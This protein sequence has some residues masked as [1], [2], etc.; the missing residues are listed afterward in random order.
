MQAESN[1]FGDLALSRRRANNPQPYAPEASII[2]WYDAYVIR[3]VQRIKRYG[4]KRITWLGLTL[5]AST[6]ERASV[7]NYDKDE[8]EDE[9]GWVTQWNLRLLG[10]NIWK[11]T[12]SEATEEI[13]S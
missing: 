13:A 4:I 8:H 7:F 2:P 9:T 12:W 11:Q 1:S 3:D 10:F 6:I 5:F